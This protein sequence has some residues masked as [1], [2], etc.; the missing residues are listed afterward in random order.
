MS[1]QLCQLTF[2]DLVTQN[3]NPGDT[4]DLFQTCLESDELEKLKTLIDTNSN[5]LVVNDILSK[6][7]ESNL[8]NPNK[9]RYNSYTEKEYK[10]LLQEQQNKKNPPASSTFQY[11]NNYYNGCYYD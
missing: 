8:I 7:Q 10:K 6:L 9:N 1:E 3:E 11:Y 2:S 5:P 4:D